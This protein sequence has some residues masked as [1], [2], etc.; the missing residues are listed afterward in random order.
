MKMLL[1]PVMAA[2]TALLFL[3]ACPAAA[4]SKLNPVLY[5][6]DYNPAPDIIF[7]GTYLGE[8]EER[9]DAALYGQAFYFKVEQAL[10]GQFGPTQTVVNMDKHAQEKFTFSEGKRYL[11]LARKIEVS[12]FNSSKTVHLVL[13]QNAHLLAEKE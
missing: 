10:K 13:P 2:L 11:I 3:S 4:E 9:F 7:V 12:G 6:G 8:E 1:T 5:T